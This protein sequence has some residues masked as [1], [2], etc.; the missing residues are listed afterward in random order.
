[1]FLSSK[2]DAALPSTQQTAQIDTHA[3]G[4][5]ADKCAG[6]YSSRHPPPLPPRRHPQWSPP[7]C[8]RAQPRSTR[9]HGPQPRL[10]PR[11]PHHAGQRAAARWSRASLAGTQRWPGSPGWKADVWAPPDAEVR[12]QQD[13]KKLRDTRVRSSGLTPTLPSPL[14][15]RPCAP[16]KFWDA[17]LTRPRYRS[18][19]TCCK[20]HAWAIQHTPLK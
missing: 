7:R 5:C 4:T 3:Y 16:M 10:Q 1:M 20:R 12:A 18:A 17:R 2:V 6:T 13:R 14:M 11:H 15:L 8:A 9:R 19:L